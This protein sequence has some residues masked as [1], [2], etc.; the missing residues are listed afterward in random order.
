VRQWQRPISRW[1]AGGDCS[2][3]NLV[4]DLERFRISSNHCV[5][6][7]VEHELRDH[8]LVAVGLGSLPIS[9]PLQNASY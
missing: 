2:A 7:I 9:K 1:E 6:G 4:P 8:C 3:A 5:S